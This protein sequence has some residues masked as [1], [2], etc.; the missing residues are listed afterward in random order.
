MDWEPALA[1]T[2]RRFQRDRLLALAAS[3]AGAMVFVATSGDFGPVEG[4]WAAAAVLVGAMPM[5]V[6][7]SLVAARGFTAIRAALRERDAASVERFARAMASL[8]LIAALAF[9][10]V[11]LL[12]ALSEIPAGWSSA[13]TWRSTW[14]TRSWPRACTR[15][16]SRSPPSARSAEGRRIVERATG[17]GRPPRVRRYGVTGRFAIT[18]AGLLAYVIGALLIA[19]VHACSVAAA[20]DP[21]G[22]ACWP[23]GAGRRRDRADYGTLAMRADR[24]APSASRS[25]RSRRCSGGPGAATSPRLREADALPAC[26]TRSAFWPT[27]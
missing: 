10:L 21:R 23:G 2:H 1:A 24:A 25:R 3:F 11:G 26:R 5:G 4:L 15:P 7:G 18:I 8:P 19:A 20:G 27:R 12:A 13:A 22:R 9:P 16:W 14:S 17:I 6:A